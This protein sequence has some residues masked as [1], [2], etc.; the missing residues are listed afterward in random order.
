MPAFSKES[1]RR[2]VLLQHGQFL[3]RLVLG[4]VAATIH[5]TAHRQTASNSSASVNR[6]SPSLYAHPDW[7]Q[8]KPADVVSIERVVKSFYEAISSESGHA[9]DRP[10]LR[11]FLCPMVQLRLR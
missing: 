6:P 11:S 10:R 1:L 9:I 4:L 3:G 7:P 2:K 8:A 5:A